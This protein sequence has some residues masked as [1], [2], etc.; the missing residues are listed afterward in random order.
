MREV[1]LFDWGDT[2]MVDFPDEQGK[3]CNWD[4]VEAVDGAAEALSFLVK[5]ADLYIATSAAASTEADILAALARVDLDKYI[6]GCFCKA[7]LGVDKSSASFYS[8]IL[9]RLEKEPTQVTMVGDSFKK[10]IEPALRLRM[11]VIW[12]TKDGSTN[13]EKGIRVVTSLRELCK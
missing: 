12:L 8:M 5:R 6:S 10:D 11:N 2:L 13:P 7:N 3:M 1:F 4:I 9:A